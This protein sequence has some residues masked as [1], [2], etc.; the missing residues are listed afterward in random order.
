[1]V[2]VVVFKRFPD[3]LSGYGLKLVDTV[4]CLGI[5]DHIRPFGALGLAIFEICGSGM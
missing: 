5:S 3:C 2:G 1:M 4:G